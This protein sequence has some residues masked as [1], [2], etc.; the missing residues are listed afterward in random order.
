MFYQ[1]IR[2]PYKSYGHEIDYPCKNKYKDIIKHDPLEEINYQVPIM[3][4]S[5]YNSFYAILFNHTNS[6]ARLVNYFM[7][8]ILKG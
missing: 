2:V 6:D 3:E 5:I 7:T 8:F 4:F 1:L